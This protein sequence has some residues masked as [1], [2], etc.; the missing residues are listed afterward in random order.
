M[1]EICPCITFFAKA[2]DAGTLPVTLPPNDDDNNDDD[3]KYGDDDGDDK[4]LMAMMT[5][6]MIEKWLIQFSPSSIH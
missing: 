3:Y 5:I 2:A 4:S 6:L 1:Y